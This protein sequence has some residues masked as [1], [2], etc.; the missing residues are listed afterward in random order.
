[1]IL[2]INSYLAILLG[3][4]VVIG[5]GATTTMIA[6]AGLVLEGRRNAEP[7]DEPPVDPI[8]PISPTNE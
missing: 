4:A 1:M 7:E 5:S 3:L 8:G 2:K 6:L